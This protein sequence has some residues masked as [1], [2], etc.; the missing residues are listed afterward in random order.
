MATVKIPAD[1]LLK[2]R[3]V[4]DRNGPIIAYTNG[5]RWVVPDPNDKERS[6]NIR[7]QYD[8]GWYISMERW[9]L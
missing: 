3:G 7:E 8:Q 9:K 5:I 4:Q 6:K 2:Q 1:M